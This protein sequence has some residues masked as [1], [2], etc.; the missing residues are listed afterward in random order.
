LGFGVYESFKQKQ[1]PRFIQ[2]KQMGEGYYV[3]GLEPANCYVEG[4]ARERENNTLQYIEAGEIKVFEVEL[5]VLDGLAEIAH[6][7]ERIVSLK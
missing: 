3:M 6:F 7:K 2:W 4:R 1:L 5:G